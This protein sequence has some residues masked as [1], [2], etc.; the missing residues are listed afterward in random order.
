MA[1]NT[2]ASFTI[3]P[4]TMLALAIVMSVGKAPPPSFVRPTES[5][6][7][8]LPLIFAE[9]FISSLTI[10]PLLI[11]VEVTEPVS[12]V[13]TTVPVISGIVIVLSAVGLVTDSVVSFA[14][15]LLPSKTSDPVRVCEP[16][17]LNKSLLTIS[18]N[19]CKPNN[20]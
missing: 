12:P 6:N 3:V 11:I 8:L 9:A 15:S 4:F 19:S 14:S 13:V 10:V 20:I 2:A 16:S 7:N 18:T 1:T 5:F 17:L